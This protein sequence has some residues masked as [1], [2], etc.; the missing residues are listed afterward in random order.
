[1]AEELELEATG[2]TVGEAKWHALRELERVSPGIDRSAVEFEVLSEGERGLLG[3]GRLPARVLAR[4]QAPPALPTAIAS[5]LARTV[6]EVLER[7]VDETGTACRVDVVEGESEVAA[8]LSGADVGLLIGR[9]G[10]TIDALQFVIEAIVHQRWHELEKEVVVDAGG[11]RRRRR[12]R[13]EMLAIRSAERVQTTLRPIEL[14]P[15][16]SAERKIVHL[17]LREVAGVETRSEGE[18]PNRY[19]VIVPASELQREE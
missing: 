11:Y 17:C 3:V 8:S 10:Q 4:V 7:I 13:L 6:K 14:E 12:G 16:S 19:V 2:E 1:M 15:M 18:E 5:D 9:R